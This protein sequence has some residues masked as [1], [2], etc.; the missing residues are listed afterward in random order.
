MEG[1]HL[2]FDGSNTAFRANM[3]SDMSTKEGFRTA[4]IYGTLNITHSNILYLQKEYELPVK[5]VIYA[6][7]LG[8][9]ARR[10]EIF[11]EYKA[12]RKE[13]YTPENQDFF[14]EFY[15][16]ID[17]LHQSLNFFGIKSYRKS[18]WE[19]DDL[20]YGFLVNLR[21]KYPD[22][23]IVIISTDEDFHQLIDEHTDVFSPIKKI[24]YT[25][26]NYET[27]MG[28]S[29]KFYITYKILKGDASDGIPGIEG[30]GEKTAKSIVKKFGD[31]QSILD[32]GEILSKSKRTARI[33]TKEGFH[34]LERNNQLINLK[35]YV[36]IKDIQ[37]NLEAILDI[38]PEI[39]KSGII[40]FFKKYQMVSLL[41]G[42]SE[43]IQPFIEIANNFKQK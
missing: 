33:F 14:K 5:E 21:K 30:I 7:D 15:Q 19:G 8:H 23:K 17:I 36:D 6:W 2:L 29:P 24:L 32:N 10:K 26:E 22:D 42:F 3:V 11:P 4:A 39:N 34:I 16:Q 18:Y 9:S 37:S 20:I 43:W 12:A 38:S 41:T 35:E 1:L 25:F 28:I 27:L 40:E 31:I 13:R